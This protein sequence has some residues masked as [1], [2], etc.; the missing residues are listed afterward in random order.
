MITKRLIGTAMFNS[1]PHPRMVIGVL[2]DVAGGPLV[3][4]IVSDMGAG[5]L[6]GVNVSVFPAA[7]MAVLELILP[8]TIEESVL[9]S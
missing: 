1:V 4:N 5:V 9:V 7:V 2:S 6:V 8:V 3:I